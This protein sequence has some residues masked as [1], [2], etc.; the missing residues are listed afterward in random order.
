MPSLVSEPT[1]S[2]STFKKPMKLI[3]PYTGKM[4]C[5]VCGSEHWANLKHGGG[6]TKGAWQCCN[7]HCPTNRQIWDVEKQRWVKAKSPSD[8]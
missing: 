4:E 5:R 1:I 6:Y 8:L 2:A 7:E 3:D